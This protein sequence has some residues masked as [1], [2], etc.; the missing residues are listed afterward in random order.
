MALLIIIGNQSGFTPSQKQIIIDKWVYALLKQKP[1]LDI[2]VWPNVKNPDDI[3]FALVW[4][5]LNGELNSYR[6]LKAISSLGAGV[7]HILTDPELPLVPVV[8]IFDDI[9]ARDIMQYVV[10]IVLNHVKRIPYWDIC[11]KEKRW[12]KQPPFNF[13]NSTIGI[14]GLGFL[15]NRTANALLNLG[16]PV[17]AWGRSEKQI[18]HLKYYHGIEQLNE[19]LSKT[20]ILVCMLPLTPSTENILDKDLFAKLPKGAY[21]INV[22]RGKHLVEKD[23]LEALASGQIG[24]AYLDVFCIEPLPL[25]HP[26]WEHPHIHVTPHIASVTEP[27]NAAEQVLENY[28]RALSGQKLSHEVSRDHGY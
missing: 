27:E 22:A 25:E 12:A 14:M 2:Q 13:A 8:R 10:A 16:L 19:F 1:N 3:D 5:Q 26:F 11:Q 4:G 7:E 6:N 17:I 23:L 28:Q 21:L 9:L 20:Q 24:E 18:D 15:G